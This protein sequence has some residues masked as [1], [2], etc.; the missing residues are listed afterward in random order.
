MTPEEELLL[1]TRIPRT[2]PAVLVQRKYLP[3]LS[4]LIDRLSIVQLK[5]IFIPESA[6]AY[7]EERALIEHDI[8]MLL[9]DKKLTAKDIRAILVVMLANRVIWESES[10][11]RAGGDDQDKLLKFTHSIN[12]VRNAAKNIIAKGA[13]ERID[14]KVDAFAEKLIAEFGAWDIFK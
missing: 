6:Q 14:L 1:V 7:N 9:A 13:S 2:F 10:R 11:A 8:D 3:T 4:D 12:G 5:A